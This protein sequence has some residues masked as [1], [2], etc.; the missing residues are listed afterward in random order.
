MPNNLQPGLRN[1]QQDVYM[2]KL[3][4]EM[5]ESMTCFVPRAR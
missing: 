3:I 5:V 1:I 4:Q 2:T